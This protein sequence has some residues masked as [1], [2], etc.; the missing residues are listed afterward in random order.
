MFKIWKIFE[1]VIKY[2]FL[3]PKL[4]LKNYVN[5]ILIK[6]VYQLIKKDTKTLKITNLDPS[7]SRYSGNIFKNYYR[8][9][10][11]FNYLP[12][13]IN[14]LPRGFK[15]LHGTNL[16]IFFNIDI[17][18]PY[19]R[20][21]REIAF[22]AHGKF[23]Y[24]CEQNCSGKWGRIQEYVSYSYFFEKANDAALFK[25]FFTDYIKEQLDDT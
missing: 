25:I 12:C 19:E 18:K 10:M 3:L 11:P 20:A 14:E 8:L 1:M 7:N 2:L 13:V 5:P 17:G 24:W 4:I 21:F 15:I 6:Y 23:E 16:A 9:E 22:F